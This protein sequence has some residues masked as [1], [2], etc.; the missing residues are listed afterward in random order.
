[1][2]EESRKTPFSEEELKRIAKKKILRSMAF[3]I[4][5]AAFICVNLFLFL[6]NVYVTGG[7]AWFVFPLAGWSIGIAEH[8]AYYLIYSRGVIGTEK[9]GLIMHAVAY[10]VTIPALFAIN[11]VSWGY[12]P[13]MGGN[14]L[15]GVYPWFLWPACF[16]LVGLV[17]HAVAVKVFIP[18]Q[19]VTG[20]KKS[21][22]DKKIE[23]EVE[24]ANTPQGG[25]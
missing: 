19:E 2:A 16:W 15:W 5:L 18:H 8:G 3:K 21:W 10:C 4:H 22:L 13:G 20:E 11:M 9:I 12:A 7:R 24:R 1:M 17:I 25:I 23:Q 6:L 14:F